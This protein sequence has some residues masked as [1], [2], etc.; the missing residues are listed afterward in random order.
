MSRLC[1][2]DILYGLLLLGG[3]ACFALV[4]SQHQYTSFVVAGNQAVAEKRFDT[5]AYDYA[6]RFWLANQDMLLFNQGVLAYEAQNLSQAAD[7]FRRVSQRTH[8][9]ALRMQALYN[10]GMVMLALN[11]VETAAELGKEALRIDPL[12]KETKFN[13]ERLYQWVL[14]KEDEQGKSSLEQAP[15]LGK[16]QGEGLS[17][18]GGGRSTPKS[19]I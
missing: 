14:L 17:G 5:Q 15:G 9:P 13:L 19:D 1:D 7:H 2:K 12:D 16:D 8:N 3:V 10:L 4:F 18:E 11:E 6:S